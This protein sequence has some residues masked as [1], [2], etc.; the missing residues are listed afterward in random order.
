ME[1]DGVVRSESKLDSAKL[2]GEP[3]IER[4]SP[5]LCEQE[6]H[7]AEGLGVKAVMGGSGVVGDGR[8][9]RDGRRDARRPV[10]RKWRKDLEVPPSGEEQNGP[11]SRATAQ[12][13]EHS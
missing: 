3:A 7:D 6:A 11:R 5:G 8:L 13:S 12:E 1:G 2:T 9:W 4:R 10:R